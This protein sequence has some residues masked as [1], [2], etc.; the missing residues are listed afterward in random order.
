MAYFR[1]PRPLP[2]RRYIIRACI[3][4]VAV[5][6]CLL[7]GS[8]SRSEPGAKYLVSLGETT[9]AQYLRD[10]TLYVDPFIG[11]SGAG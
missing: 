10:N 6:L 9:T 1:I 11:T 5:A 4:F 2:F 7:L 8:I 3:I